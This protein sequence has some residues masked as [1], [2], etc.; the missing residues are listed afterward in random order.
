VGQIFLDC[1]DVLYSFFDGE[2]QDVWKTEETMTYWLTED[3]FVPMLTGIFMATVL[4]LMAWSARNRLVLYAGLLVAILTA[5]IVVAEAAIVTDRETVTELVYELAGYVR[6]N[7]A[8]SIA[9]HISP[10]SPELIDRMRNRMDRFK[11]ETC[12]ITGVNK[13]SIEGG[14]ATID[15]VAFGQGSEKRSGLKSPANPRVELKLRKQAD[16]MWKI[17]GYTISNPRSGVS[18]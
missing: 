10:Q 4:L 18:L 6:A 8:N 5:G 3:A 11:V 15:F 9:Q 14:V 17:I 1:D 7:D 16:E 12:S 13:F 2:R